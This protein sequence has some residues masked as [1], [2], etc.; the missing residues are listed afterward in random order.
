MLPEF[1]EIN[2]KPDFTPPAEWAPL[3]PSWV[4]AL[5]VGTALLLTT[6]LVWQ[7]LRGIQRVETPP[8]PPLP[9]S[10]QA[11]QMLQDLRSRQEQFSVPRFADQVVQVIRTWLHRSFGILA[12]YRT[13]EEILHL[14]TDR[15]QPPPPPVL[16]DFQDYLL[17]A[18]NIVF[19]P[20]SAWESVEADLD[21]NW[22]VEDALRMI[23]KDRIA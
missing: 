10:Q 22:L 14:R 2:D 20:E 16:R 15:S 7:M 23:R 3:L 8:P 9:P 18:R 13:A 4:W 1:P 19:S 11:I 5:I 17:K 21:K 12:N 6:V